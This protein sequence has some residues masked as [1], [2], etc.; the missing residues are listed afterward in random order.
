VSGLPCLG[1]TPGLTSFQPYGTPSE[2][3]ASPK[4]HCS[5][6]LDF[7]PRIRNKCHLASNSLRQTDLLSTYKFYD[8]SLSDK[9]EHAFQALA[10]D[11][12]RAPFSPAVWERLKDNRNMT[13]LRQVWFP[14]NHGNCGGGWPDTGIANLSLTC[15]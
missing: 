3:L 5:V 1:L 4:Y 13:D 9:I 7:C 2:A 6:N 12:T 14:G 10:L 15:Q 11:E 8:T